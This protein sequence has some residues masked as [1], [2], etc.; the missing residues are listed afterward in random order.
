MDDAYTRLQMAEVE[1]LRVKLAEG[2]ATV[3]V[4][5]PLR[6]YAEDTRRFFGVLGFPPKDVVGAIQE[7][8]EI[9]RGADPAQ[10]Y[11]PPEAL[12]LTVKNIRTIADP[13]NFTADDLTKVSKILASI[14]ARYKPLP[15]HGR[16]VLVMPTSISIPVYSIK[17]FGDL[18]VDLDSA[19]NAAGVPDDKKY[20][21]SSVF[22]TNITIARFLKTPSPEFYRRLK[23]V[24]DLTLPPFELSRLDLVCSNLAFSDGQVTRFDSCDLRGK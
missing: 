1:A 17:N 20:T 5:E 12:H 11:I 4:V 10:F 6:S 18:V 9:L 16:G 24:S 13:P 2:S 21:S 22:F 23:Q 15:L 14:S 19:M 7:V 8:Q 3:T